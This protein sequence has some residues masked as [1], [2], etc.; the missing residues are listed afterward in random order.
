[1]MAATVLPLLVVHNHRLPVANT[2]MNHHTAMKNSKICGFIFTQTG[3][4]R[5]IDTF[6]TFLFAIPTTLS[7]LSLAKDYNCVTSEQE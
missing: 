3:M 1:M 7:L 5:K 4:T 2:I 6:D